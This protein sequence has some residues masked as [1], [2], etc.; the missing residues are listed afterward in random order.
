MN[1]TV[2]SNAI[3][4][5]KT[6]ALIIEDRSN[7]PMVLPTDTPLRVNHFANGDA[8][9]VWQGNIVAVPADMVVVL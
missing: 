8:I 1:L 3:T 7:T 6:W 9:G 5:N 4:T 2:D